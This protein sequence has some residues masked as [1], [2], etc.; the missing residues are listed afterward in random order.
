LQ[1]L[2]SKRT[3]LVNQLQ[4]EIIALIQERD[5][6]NEDLQAFRAE[7]A[8]KVRMIEKIAQNQEKV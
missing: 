1:D 4:N 3:I 7:L 5:A 6:P 8:S 2:K